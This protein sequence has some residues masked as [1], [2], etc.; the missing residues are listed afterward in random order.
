MSTEPP[1]PVDV[2]DPVLHRLH[3]GTGPSAASWCRLPGAG[4]RILATVTGTAVQI[5]G[6]PGITVR[7]TATALPLRTRSVDRVVLPLSLH[8]LDRP[9]VVLAEVRRVLAPHGLVSVLVPVPP[10]FGWRGRAERRGLRE[11]WRHPSC[12]DHPDWVAASADFAV[13]ADD[14]LAFTLG[15]EPTDAGAPDD[16]SDPAEYGERDALDVLCRAGIYPDGLPAATREAL[17]RHR[18]ASHTVRLRRIVARR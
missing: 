15:R 16:H 11:A 13:L 6:A 3:A 10:S 4:A 2:L 14:R 12:V 8:R 5:E 7:G 9:D 1:S 18:T 17:R